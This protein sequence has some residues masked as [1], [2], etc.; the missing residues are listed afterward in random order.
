MYRWETTINT[1]TGE[2][3]TTP[4]AIAEEE[5][6]SKETQRRCALYLSTKVNRLA[7]RDE[8]SA[9]HA[10]LFGLVPSFDRD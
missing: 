7:E 6:I 10:S 8:S 5:A 2:A 3:Q 9:L 4:G 1:E